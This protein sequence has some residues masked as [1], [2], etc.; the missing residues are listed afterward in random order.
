MFSVSLPTNG[1]LP[2]AEN[3]KELS[4]AGPFTVFVPRTDFIGNTTTVSVLPPQALSGVWQAPVVLI[5]RLGLFC[6]VGPPPRDLNAGFVK[7]V[8][9]SQSSQMVLC[10]HHILGGTGFSAGM[11]QRGLGQSRSAHPPQGKVPPV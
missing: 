2:Q 8:E 5:F 7:L 6:P 3:I 11:G 10:V 4:G 9:I 1:L